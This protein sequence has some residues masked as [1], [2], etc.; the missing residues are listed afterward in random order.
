MA[1]ETNP[2]FQTPYQ[3]NK[4][5]RISNLQSSAKVQKDAIKRSLKK[6]EIDSDEGDDND[7]PDEYESPVH[8]KKRG[9]KILSVKVLELVEQEG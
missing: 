2:M 4:R 7:D 1:E 3:T 6:F 5:K 9:L 8:R